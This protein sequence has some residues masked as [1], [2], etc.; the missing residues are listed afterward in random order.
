M[1]L[2]RAKSVVAHWLG[3]GPIGVR[4]ANDQA[5]DRLR[6]L[7]SLLMMMAHCPLLGWVPGSQVQGI[8]SFGGVASGVH[9]GLRP[10]YFYF[11]GGC[12][13]RPLVQSGGRRVQTLKQEIKQ[14]VIK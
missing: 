13:R 9:L 8:V 6:K 5:M 12:S 3:G 10:F 2:E 14:P 1:T 11:Y 7:L 4:Q